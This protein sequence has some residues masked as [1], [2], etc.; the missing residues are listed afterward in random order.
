MEIPRPSHSAVTATASGTFTVC[1]AH[2]TLF[3]RSGKRAFDVVIASIGLILFSPIFFLSS[4][5]V[6]L[7]SRGPLICPQRRYSY[8]NKAFRIVTFRCTAT[9]SV[10]TAAQTARR[11]ACVTRIGHILRSSGLDEFP[12]LINVLR[13]EMSIVGHRPYTTHPDPLSQEQIS[14]T[15]R[16][17]NIKPGLTGWAQV[18]GYWDDNNS[19]RVMR[20]RVEYDLYYVENWSFLLDMKIILMTLCS[21]S[22]YASTEWTSDR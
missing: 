12:Q 13:G 21:R 3:A 6:K 10:E 17:S 1:T 2:S 5:A 15:T 14:L 9:E 7:D 16:R 4:L 18:H 20:R 8:G 11:S 19:I 22:A